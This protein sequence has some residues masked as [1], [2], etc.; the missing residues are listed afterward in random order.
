MLNGIFFEKYVWQ[1]F[2]RIDQNPFQNGFVFKNNIKSTFFG[3]SIFEKNISKNILLK[4]IK[5]HFKIDF[6]IKFA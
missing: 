6:N 4:S 5:K 1:I 3:K 2:L